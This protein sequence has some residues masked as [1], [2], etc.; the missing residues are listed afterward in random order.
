MLLGKKGDSSKPQKLI[1]SGEEKIIAV[2]NQFGEKQYTANE[3]AVSWS[4]TGVSLPIG[5]IITP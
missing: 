4:L 5:L 2:Q 1:I 3:N